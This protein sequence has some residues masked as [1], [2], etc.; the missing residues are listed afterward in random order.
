MPVTICHRTCSTDNKGV[1]TSISK[2]YE[3]KGKL[4]EFFAGRCSF[5]G[6][7]YPKLWTAKPDMIFDKPTKELARPIPKGRMKEIQ[8][9]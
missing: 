1:C 4:D 6:S 2:P 9:T 5:E 8:P 7:C 3:I